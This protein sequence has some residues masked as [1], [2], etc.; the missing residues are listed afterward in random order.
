M[1]Y[2]F[3]LPLLPLKHFSLPSRRFPQISRRQEEDIP[4]TTHVPRELRHRLVGH[5]PAVLEHLTN[6]LLV[7]PPHRPHAPVS[8]G[9]PSVLLGTVAKVFD[10]Q[11]VGD[12]AAPRHGEP[13]D[14]CAH[15]RRHASNCRHR[16]EAHEEQTP[17]Q[18]GLL[19]CSS[20]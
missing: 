12:R 5:Q 15:H 4:L 16:N 6:V 17:A 20:E 7:H 2:Q 10:Q 8:V 18:H 14:V 3:L 1:I 13:R 11:G 19:F 9:A